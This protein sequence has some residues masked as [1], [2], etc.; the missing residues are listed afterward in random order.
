LGTNRTTNFK[1]GGCRGRKRGEKRSKG[2]AGWPTSRAG[3]ERQG[4][5]RNRRAKMGKEMVQGE[6]RTQ[7]LKASPLPYK[8]KG[9]G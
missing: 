1:P 8:W 7:D 4:R 9:T 5:E 3:G 2:V 6:G